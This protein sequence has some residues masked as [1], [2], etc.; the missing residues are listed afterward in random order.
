M[1]EPETLDVTKVSDGPIDAL[2]SA[3]YRLRTERVEWLML[4]AIVS[5]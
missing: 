5:F 2:P 1:V 4:E 3:R